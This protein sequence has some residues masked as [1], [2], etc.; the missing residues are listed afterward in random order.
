MP[1]DL[2]EVLERKLQKFDTILE[3]E[4]YFVHLYMYGCWLKEREREREGGRERARRMGEREKKGG[5]GRER[6]R[7]RVRERENNI[8]IVQRNPLKISNVTQHS[9]THMY[10]NLRNPF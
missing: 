3:K 5:G 8:E 4:V 7:E 1:P 10:H 2:I 9:C 6:E